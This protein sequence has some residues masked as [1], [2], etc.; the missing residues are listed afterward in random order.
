MNQTAVSL[1]WMENMVTSKE[2]VS[3]E[4]EEEKTSFIICNED[5]SWFL[6]KAET[7]EG[8]ISQAKSRGKEPRYAVEEKLCTSAK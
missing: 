5:E 3:I 1:P 8:A 2:S 4:T 7:M 6:L